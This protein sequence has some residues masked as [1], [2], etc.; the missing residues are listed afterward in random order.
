[1]HNKQC[2]K[3][4]RMQPLLEE[5]QL[6]FVLAMFYLSGIFFMASCFLVETMLPS[7]LLSI[8]ANTFLKL[9]LDS[10]ITNKT[11][12]NLEA[13][14]QILASHMQVPQEVTQA[15]FKMEERP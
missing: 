4:R 11:L 3:L 5:L 15:L 8:S 12:L 13:T 1:M 10:K 2:F 6:D 9:Q 14:M 7:F